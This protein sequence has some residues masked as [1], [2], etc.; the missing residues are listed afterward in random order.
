MGA[1]AGLQEAV[2]G[3]AA[4]I[5]AESTRAMDVEAGLQ[6]AVDDNAASRAFT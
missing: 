6:E 2:D 4:A 3:N 5:D 1:E